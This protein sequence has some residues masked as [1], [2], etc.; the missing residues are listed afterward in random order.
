M[1]AVA[2][3]DATGMSPETANLFDQYVVPNY[4]RFPVTLT[5]GEGSYVWDDQGKRYLDFFPGWGCNLLG[6]CPPKVVEAVQKQAAELIHVPNTWHIEAQGRWAKLLS[7]HSFGGKAFF[8]NSGA[9]ANEAAI[10]LA[11]LHTPAGK[12]KIITFEGGF[13]GRTFGAVSATA[14]PKYH[15][16]IGPMAAGFVYAPFGDL[17]R[18]A[19]KIDDETAAILV[20]PI[21]GEGGIRLPPEGFLQ[22]LRDLADEHDLLLMFDEVQ[23]GCGRTGEWFAYQ[24]FGVTPDVMTLAK[25]LCGGVAGGAMLTTAEIAPSLR[26]GMH[27]AT[28]GGNPLAAVAGIATLE[29]IEQDGLLERAKTLGAQFEEKL[30]PLVEALPHVSELRVCGLMIGIELAVDATP[31]VQACM[32]RQLLINVTQ[33]NVVRL[34]PAMTLTDELLNEGCEILADA[35]QGFEV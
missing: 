1:T 3:S 31:V 18:A 30:S 23:A 29:T 20:E 22:G 17:E 8:C 5:R 27:A 6:H 13:H 11:R 19:A 24:N 32:D 7:D 26:P 33:G 15:E 35:L 25:S 9:E 10:K 2:A 28:F 16:D 21:Q 12:Y 14:Q 4:R 34:L